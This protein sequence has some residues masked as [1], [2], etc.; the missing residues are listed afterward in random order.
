MNEE[1]RLIETIKNEKECFDKGEK[2]N[3]SGVTEGD[4]H[5]WSRF[6]P[7]MNNLSLRLNGY[8]GS[9][10]NCGR[11][12]IIHMVNAVKLCLNGLKL[13]ITIEISINERKIIIVTINGAKRFNKF[14]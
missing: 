7:C 12:I 4:T 5:F 1:V 3:C 2:A 13:L 9:L 14:R 11:I 10:Y 8:G 6:R